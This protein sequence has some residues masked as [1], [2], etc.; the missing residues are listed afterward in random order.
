MSS[1][2]MLALFAGT[3]GTA[4]ASV[5]VKTA[6]SNTTGS[7]GDSFH[8][9]LSNAV[10]SLGSSS[11][12]K[13]DSSSPSREAEVQPDHDASA[14]SNEKENEHLARSKSAT[15]SQ[16]SQKEC[17]GTACSVGNDRY[18]SQQGRAGEDQT[19]DYVIG[20]EG[21]ACAE[22]VDARANEVEGLSDVDAA[23][24]M[25]PFLPAMSQ[26][27][28]EAFNRIAALTAGGVIN[29]EILSELSDEQVS[30]LAD[31]ALAGAGGLLAPF[32]G[33]DA[34][35]E[36]AT[37]INAVGEILF[38]T[39]SAES[40]QGSG[41][42]FQLADFGLGRAAQAVSG[43]QALQQ[44][45]SAADLPGE[46]GLADTLA[47]LAQTEPLSDV[48]MGCIVSAMLQGAEAAQPQINAGMTAVQLMQSLPAE[49]VESLLQS[50][51]NAGG[52]DATLP[53]LPE[54]VLRSLGV[55]LLNVSESD[56][57]E[58]GDQ[59]LLAVL[60]NNSGLRESLMQQGTLK[61][62]VLSAQAKSVENAALAS[63]LAAQGVESDEEAAVPQI[64]SE[65]VLADEA[66]GD[67][68]EM[69]RDNP[70]ALT[71]QEGRSREAEVVEDSARET[72]AVADENSLSDGGDA[73]G[74]DSAPEGRE[75][76][77]REEAL[78][79]MNDRKA[80]ASADA[81]S[82]EFAT[83]AGLTG[84]PEDSEF[85][86]E[87]EATLAEYGLTAA[88]RTSDLTAVLATPAAATSSE[89]GSGHMAE[90][91]ERLQK[92]MQ[93]AANGGEMK[94]LSLQLNPYELGKI[95]IDLELREGAIHATIR[96][97]NDAARDMLMSG[98]DQLRQTLEA[99]GI[100]LDTFDVSVDREGYDEPDGRNAAGWRAAEEERQKQQNERGGKSSRNRGDGVEQVIAEEQA[101]V[102]PAG[103]STLNI[104]A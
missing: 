21:D 37:D 63:K 48:A 56:A 45:V 11:N 9:S 70:A 87:G 17:A 33:V 36:S 39:S 4:G 29:A 13:S 67:I 58:T 10:R 64:V 71:G 55:E 65:Q 12:A 100:K 96:T 7:S 79:L 89:T 28:Q 26:P 53:E 23:L 54:A 81:P 3:S 73:E 16:S 46:T 43:L 91:I 8:Q 5:S 92:L 59:A 80:V 49:E 31:W 62:D 14:Y 85:A 74:G 99:S 94:S 15:S 84:F 104:V 98:S 42:Q 41:G 77:M 82:E 20:D 30:D 83:L 22:D 27:Q 47:T 50:A 35:N 19:P 25:L 51:L 32:D 76:S 72:L 86:G 66:V 40:V 38:S 102:L 88:G 78:R 101:E 34:M 52:V 1:S 57:D 18:K 93:S 60:N 75:D 90:N 2:S 69:P 103:S 95:T 68:V 24:A 97:E 61:A 6:G 44:A